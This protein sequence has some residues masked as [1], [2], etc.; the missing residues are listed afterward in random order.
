MKPFMIKN[1]TYQQLDPLLWVQEHV[2]YA[3]PYDGPKKHEKEF[4]RQLNLFFWHILQSSIYTTKKHRHMKFGMVKVPF[5]RKFGQTEVPMVFGHIGS[6]Q[7][8]GAVGP[9]LEMTEKQFR[10]SLD[11]L[12]ESN[13]IERKHYN[14]DKKKSREFRIHKDVL[15]KIFVNV[16]RSG[17]DLLNTL[18]LY[19]PLKVVQERYGLT[20]REKINKSNARLFCPR[21]HEF[22]YLD[23][24]RDRETIKMY[25]TVLAKLEPNVIA[26]EPI[27]DYL[28]DKSFQKNMRAAKQFEQVKNLI[29]NIIDQGPIQIVSE[30]PLVI[31]YYPAYRA[32]RIGG[33]L[34]EIGGGFQSL[35]ADLKEKCFK[36]GSNWDMESSQFN[37]LKHE[38]TTHGIECDFLERFASVECIANELGIE[39]SVAKI[40]FYATLFN[41]GTINH[42]PKSRV[43]KALHKSCK[44]KKSN[45]SVDDFFQRW[46]IETISL[47]QALSALADIYISKFRKTQDGCTLANALGVKFNPG[48]PVEELS[49]KQK[50][51][52]LSHMI[53]GIESSLLFEAILNPAVSAVYSLE[54]DGALMNVV[55]EV[56]ANG[57]TFVQKRFSEV[58]IDPCSE[59]D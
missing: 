35:P 22:P 43:Y 52:V 55:G 34:F 18:R 28:E 32:S 31:K 17:F 24:N 12:I 5:S 50:R 27:F 13:T 44:K 57:A 47:N 40:C 37:I 29:L 8:T 2:V 21:S 49:S 58:P 53:S 7:A 6:K 56:Q 51:Q 33:R 23:R 16:P 36:I 46:D 9:N 59:D 1:P 39:K 4:R 15:A 48:V 19:S 54:H 26:I 14:R 3:C 30:S 11:W 10:R 25:R 38:L 45:V 41:G 20:I 42:S